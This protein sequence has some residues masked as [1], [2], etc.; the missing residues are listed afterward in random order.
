MQVGLRCPAWLNSFP[1]KPWDLRRLHFE[2]F[3]NNVEKGEI[4]RNERFLLFPHWLL[5]FGEL[6]IKFKIVVCKLIQFGR[7]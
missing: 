2:S 5:P 1:N 7:V 4:A 3:E 6:F